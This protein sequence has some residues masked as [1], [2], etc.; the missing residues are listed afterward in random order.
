MLAVGHMREGM[1]LGALCA[2]AR[3]VLA[4]GNAPRVAFRACGIPS[5]VRRVANGAIGG[6]II[7]FLGESKGMG[8]QKLEMMGLYELICACIGML[9]Y[10]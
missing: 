10:G 2:R 4:L 3:V 9:G 7:K 6:R 8:S 1:P 5:G